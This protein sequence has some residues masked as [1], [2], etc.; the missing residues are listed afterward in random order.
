MVIKG[1]SDTC[2]AAKK[3]LIVTRVCDYKLDSPVIGLLW[4]TPDIVDIRT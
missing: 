1:V 3:P 2:I 4:A